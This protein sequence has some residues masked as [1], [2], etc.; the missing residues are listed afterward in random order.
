MNFPS[1]ALQILLSDAA[2]K[3]RDTNTGGGKNNVYH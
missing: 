1:S 2:V 3:E